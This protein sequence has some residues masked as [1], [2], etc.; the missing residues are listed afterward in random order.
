MKTKRKKQA[1]KILMSAK[2]LKVWL[3]NF[4]MA[5]ETHPKMVI[6]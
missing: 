5:E 6:L 1:R 4:D 2:N 3:Y